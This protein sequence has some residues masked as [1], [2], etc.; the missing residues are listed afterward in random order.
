MSG[1]GQRE[2]RPDAV[3]RACGTGGMLSVGEDHLRALN[4]DAVL[5][6]SNVGRR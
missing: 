5:Q 2:A 6:V 1:E 4:P 3:R